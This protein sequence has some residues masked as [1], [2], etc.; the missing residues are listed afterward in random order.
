MC[1][2]DCDGF[3]AKVLLIQHSRVQY[4]I[5]LKA[6]WILQKRCYSSSVQALFNNDLFKNLQDEVGI[7]AQREKWLM[8]SGWPLFRTKQMMPRPSLKVVT[9]IST[10]GTG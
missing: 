5:I 3:L 4:C 10:K 8:L 1:I 7:V 9:Y 2:K 6:V